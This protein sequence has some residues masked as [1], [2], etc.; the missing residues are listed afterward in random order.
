[1]LF[2]F[3][4]CADHG[5]RDFGPRPQT[6]SSIARL[7]EVQKSG[8]TGG[9]RQAP[10]RHCAIR[11][12]TISSRGYAYSDVLNAPSQ[13]KRPGTPAIS[14]RRFT[15]ERPSPQPRACRVDRSAFRALPAPSFV[16]LPAG[17]SHYAVAETESIVQINGVGPFDVVYVNQKDDPRSQ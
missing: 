8:A 11:T 5:L 16:H 14:S 17:T 7:T 13:P 9:R 15:I 2:P 1:M 10:G 3:R 6:Q 4:T 12:P